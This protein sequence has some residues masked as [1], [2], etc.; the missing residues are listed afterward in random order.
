MAEDLEDRVE[1]GVDEA[2]ALGEFGEGDA[3]PVGEGA[4][5]VVAQEGVAH[6]REALHAARLAHVHEGRAP[7]H[8]RDV[9][10][11]DARVVAQALL[12][13]IGGEDRVVVDD[14]EVRRVDPAV[15]EEPVHVVVLEEEAVEAVLDGRAL[16]AGQ[17]DVPGAELPA[18]VRAALEQPHAEASLRE[19]DRGRRTRETTADDDRVERGVEAGLADA[20]S[21]GHLHRLEADRPAEPGGE[22]VAAASEGAGEDMV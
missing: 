18:E 1:A 11:C 5:G 22:A 12:A 8:R 9:E 2:H 19:S 21:L 3:V 4:L 10:G 15:E 17:V 6:D 7:G 14:R 13:P 16:A 20:D